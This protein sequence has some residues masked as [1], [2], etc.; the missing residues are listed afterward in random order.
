MMKKI[1]IALSILLVYIIMRFIFS[2]TIFN[3]PYM[4]GTKTYEGYSKY[5]FPICIVNQI[6]VKNV[7]KN[8]INYL[9]NEAQEA[10][11]MDIKNIC[12][13]F[14]TLEDP[15]D[16]DIISVAISIEGVSANKHVNSFL[17]QQKENPKKKCVAIV[18][19]KSNQILKF[20][21]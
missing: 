4:F 21:F 9:K 20:R 3:V 15:L 18:E 8:I 5:D 17:L 7:K 14:G 19:K 16:F 10:E 11:Q 12:D 1:I 2:Y 6:K 13:F